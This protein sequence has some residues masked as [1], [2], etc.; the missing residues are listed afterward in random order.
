MRGFFLPT[1]EC[2]ETVV[3]G[4]TLQTG[5]LARP[6]LFFIFKSYDNLPPQAFF[7]DPSRLQGTRL[8]TSKDKHPDAMQEPLYLFPSLLSERGFGGLFSGCEALSL[9]FLLTGSG[10]LPHPYPTKFLRNGSR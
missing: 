5:F 2:I 7:R 1:G 10:T 9:P 6:Y 3:T 4:E 8:P